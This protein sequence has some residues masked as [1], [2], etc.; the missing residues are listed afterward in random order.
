MPII[1]INTPN[2]IADLAQIVASE[3]IIEDSRVL[4]FS[5]IINAVFALKPTQDCDTLQLFDFTDYQELENVNMD[6]L[7]INVYLARHSSCGEIIEYCSTEIQPNVTT[8]FEN[9]KEDGL[10]CAIVQI[11]YIR[12]LVPYT[13]IIHESYE[14]DCC[15][16]L[17]SKLASEMKIKMAKIG[18]S[19]V[20][21]SK[22][23]R[24]IVKLKDSYL[25]ISN[26]MWVYNNSVDSCYEGDKVHCIYNKIK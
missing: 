12:D 5:D 7:T 1:N 9:L 26:L 15:T 6:N 2:L 10:Y 21:F 13:S 8:T 18:C 25:K 16:E 22:V 4:V 19:I 23:G 11:D 20:K 24:N 17:F 14:K 3:I